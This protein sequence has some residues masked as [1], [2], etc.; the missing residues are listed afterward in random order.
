MD[1]RTPGDLGAVARG[2]RRA[3]RL[4]QTKVA[5]AA[6]VSRVWLAEFEN[7]KPTVEL[8]RVLSVLLT[9]DLIVDVSAPGE[10][11]AGAATELD[12]DSLME[13]YNRGAE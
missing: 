12:L 11:V 4:S 1:I 9:L 5:E 8:G 2:R 7:G 13:E 10:P 6:G 3:L